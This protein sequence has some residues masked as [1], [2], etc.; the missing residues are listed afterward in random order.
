MSK[1]TG[2]LFKREFLTPSEASKKTLHLEILTTEKIS[3]LPGDSIAVDVINPLP[4]VKKWLKKHNRDKNESIEHRR[5]KEIIDLE[6]YLLHHVNLQSIGDGSLERAR[7]LMP[8]FYSIASSN[9]IHPNTLHLLITLDEFVADDGEPTMGVASHFFSNHLTLNDPVTFKLYPNDTFR[10]PA[11]ETP[12]IMIGSGTGLAP[13]KA[14]LE[15]RVATNA[16]GFNWLIFGEQYRASH[17]YYA[18]FFTDL[19]AKNLLKLSLAFSRDQAEKIYVQDRLAQEASTLFS[20]LDQGAVI[21][22]CGD[23]KQMAKGVTET[24]ETLFQQKTACT[25]DE[26]RDWLRTLKAKKQL[27]LDVY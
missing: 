19:E 26:A 5:T 16:S 1:F 23:A 9:R 13:Y 27:L 17:F 25:D 6:S 4:Q 20:L 15:E 2:K 18:P 7:P 10:L 22:I 8:R 21:Y 3:Y 24:L 12:I 14:F 11:P